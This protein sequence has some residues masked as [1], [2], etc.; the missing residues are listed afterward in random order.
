MKNI[1]KNKEDGPL[2]KQGGFI[3][4]IILI[5]IAL[6][7]MKYLGITVSGVINWFMSFFRS[8]FR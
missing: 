1:F 4:L 6:L 3:E 8:V 7:L 5:V 2:S